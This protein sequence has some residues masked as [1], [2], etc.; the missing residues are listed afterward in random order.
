[1]AQSANLSILLV[2]PWT[3]HV[4]ALR[5]ALR[6]E[7]IDAEIATADFEVRLRAAVEQRPF[8]VA[9][10]VATP[11]LPFDV[12]ESLVRQ[13]APKLCVTMHDNLD[14]VLAEIRRFAVDR[15]S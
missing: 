7:G 4:G 8:A 9:Y 3:T 13:H 14:G 1:M 5:A 12:V 2:C 15:R 10:Y 11:G 6:D